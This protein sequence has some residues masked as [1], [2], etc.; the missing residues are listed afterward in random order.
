[1]LFDHFDPSASSSSFFHVVSYC[2]VRTFPL[3]YE[4]RSRDRQATASAWE[5]AV[6]PQV[7]SN[8]PRSFY[9]LPHQII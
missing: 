9:L 2:L 4:F 7:T 8:L 6:L 1:M 3:L 5:G